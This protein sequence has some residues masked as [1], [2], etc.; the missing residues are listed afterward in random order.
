MGQDSYTISNGYLT[1][2]ITAVQT[3]SR[4]GSLLKLIDIQTGIN[5][6]E[7]GQYGSVHCG[8]FVPLD[9]SAS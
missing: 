7:G 2:V 5:F 4:A 9:G 8:D 3:D 1:A 6:A